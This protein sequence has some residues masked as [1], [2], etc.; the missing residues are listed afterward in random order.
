MSVGSM[1]QSGFS[2]ATGLIGISRG[3][4]AFACRQALA[5]RRL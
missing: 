5:H 2:V 3:Q 1:D 4:T